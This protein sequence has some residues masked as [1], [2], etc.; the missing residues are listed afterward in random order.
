[1]WV[2]SWGESLCSG[3]VKKI[4]QDKRACVIHLKSVPVRERKEALLK[5][6]TPSPSTL[7]RLGAVYGPQNRN[8]ELNK[9]PYNYIT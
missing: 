7:N 4:F 1:M 2:G 6:G 3:L 5:A 8:K 9:I